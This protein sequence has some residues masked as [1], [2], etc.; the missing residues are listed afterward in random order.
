MAAAAPGGGV[1]SFAS[2]GTLLEV[3]DAV[4]LRDGRSILTTVGVRRFR[5]LSRD[6]K[7]KSK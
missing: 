6:E 2:Y 5:V 3:R 1:Q 4:H 7:V